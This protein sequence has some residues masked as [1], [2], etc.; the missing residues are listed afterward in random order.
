MALLSST[1]VG[2]LRH[3]ATMRLGAAGAESN[4]AIGVRRLGLPAAWM[5]RVGDDEL[6][7]LVLAKLRGEQVDVDAAVLDGGGPTGLMIKEQRTADIARVVYHRRHSAGSRLEPRDLDEARIRAARVLH[8]TGITPALGA[9]ARAAVHA[10]IDVAAGA[11][12]LVSLDFNYRAALWSAEE[13]AAELRD[14]T[15]R[16]DLAALGPRHAVVKRGPA[17]AVAVVDGTPHTV[18]APR[19][20]E[21]GLPGH[22]GRLRRLRGHRARGLGGAPDLGGAAPPRALERHRH[23]LTAA[24]GAAAARLQGRRGPPPIG[25]PGV[26]GWG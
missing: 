21:R 16:A 22:R 15:G 4:V 5:G 17:G 9:S 23:P 12:T 19:V 1:E 8:L 26:A 25:V 11:G 10:A 18:P 24:V 6:G 3:A 7:R 13:A 20:R 14:L 2:L